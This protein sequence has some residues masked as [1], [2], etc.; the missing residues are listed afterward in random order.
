MEFEYDYTIV[1]GDGNHESGYGRRAF[2]NAHTLG[3]EFLDPGVDI[4][5]HSQR[6]WF[7]LQINIRHLRRNQDYW[8]IQPN[9]KE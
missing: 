2:I 9:G 7:I 4:P 5:V 3:D 1:N 6:N 8:F